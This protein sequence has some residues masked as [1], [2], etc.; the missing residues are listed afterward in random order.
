MNE[1]SIKEIVQKVNE[2]RADNQVIAAR[3]LLSG[4][5]ALYTEDT[6]A[7][8]GLKENTTWAKALSSQAQ[9]K[10]R[11]YEVLLKSWVVEET[12][13]EERLAR[14]LEEENKRAIPLLRIVHLRWL[15]RNPAKDTYG[16]IV[17]ELDCPETANQVIHRGLVHNMEL[18]S[19]VRFDRTMQIQQCYKC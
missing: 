17:A 9:V 15:K 13:G 5:I 1:L 16:H 18:K 14:E 3:K 6:K 19:A 12:G 11:T 4:E 7:R 2:G 10:T 8:T